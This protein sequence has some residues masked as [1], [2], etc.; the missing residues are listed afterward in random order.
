MNS[1]IVVLVSVAAAGFLGAI[2][3][4]DRAFSQGMPHQIE[5]PY[6]PP[7]AR[8]MVLRARIAST[9]EL[10]V[11]PVHGNVYAIFGAGGNITVSVGPDG[12]LLVNTGEAAM[13]GKVLEVVKK[14]GAGIDPTP[15]S[16]PIPIRIIIN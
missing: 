7:S 15:G 13:A 12:I 1:K 9:A 3:S 11:E 2:G 8:E 14:L 16:P 4:V 10:N 6:A 5:H